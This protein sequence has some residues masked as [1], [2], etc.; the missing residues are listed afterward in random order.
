MNIKG[1][2][3]R[4]IGVVSAVIKDMS[5]TDPFEILTKKYSAAP[6]VA[7]NVI[8]QLTVDKVWSICDMLGPVYEH[9]ACSNVYL[10]YRPQR[11]DMFATFSLLQ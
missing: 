8:T 1:Q 9:Y 10:K 11:L 5:A 7:F 3:W 4:I 6:K 2:G